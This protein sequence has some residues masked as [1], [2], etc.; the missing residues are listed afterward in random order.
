MA[1]IVGNEALPVA[2]VGVDRP[3][4]SIGEARGLVKDLFVHKPHI[5]WIDFLV[6]LTVGYVAGSFYLLAP[7]F[8][9]W[10]FLLLVVAGFALFRL[11]SFIH[12]IVHFR[13]GEMTAFSI[14]WNLLAGVPMLMPSSFYENHIDHHNNQHYGT[15][16]DGE[17]LPL[18]AGPFRQVLW[19]FLQALLL[20]IL[21]IFRFLFLAPLSCIHPGF[22]AWVRERFSSYA[23]NY[24]YR[25]AAVKE[26]TPTFWLLMEIA[27]FFRAWLIFVLIAIGFNEPHHL[28]LLYVLAVVVLGLNYVRN[29]TAH[30]YR[31]HGEAM[32]HEEQLLDS[33]NVTG[34]WFTELIFPLSLRYHALHHLFPHLPYHN[35]AAAHR[36]LVAH[37]APD[38]L[39]HQTTFPSYWSVVRELATSC[40]EACLSSPTGSEKWYSTPSDRKPQ[41]RPKPR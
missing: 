27:C 3:Q 7:L 8:S 25:R 9:I 36:R 20:P 5:Y 37:F 13:Q 11:G 16:N 21:V 24:S 31:G 23:M 10:Q 6:T 14:A 28:V 32:S 17:Y 19:Y 39:Y 41:R 35:L 26:K 12:E 40:K 2:E 22:R 29:L 15:R 33:V 38:S 1:S 34:G 18:G 30:R 4:F